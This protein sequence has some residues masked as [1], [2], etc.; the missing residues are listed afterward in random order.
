MLPID[1]YDPAN[2]RH[3]QIFAKLAPA[4]QVA[5]S[6]YQEQIQRE[7]D[8]KNPGRFRPTSGF[9]CASENARV[10]GV[11]DSLHIWGMARDFVPVD[12]DFSRE[13]SV[14]SRRYRV[15]RSPKCWHIEVA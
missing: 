12:G 10:G 11:P 2:P 9:R 13:P 5:I 8:T 6:C 3:G 4:I 1:T 7:V 14:C 15:H